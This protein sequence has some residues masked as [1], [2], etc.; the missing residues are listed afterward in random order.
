MKDGRVGYL[1]LCARMKIDVSR[2]KGVPMQFLHPGSAI[3]VFVSLLAAGVTPQKAVS[4]KSFHLQSR[5]QIQLNKSSGEIDQVIELP[6]GN[7]MVRDST[8]KPLEAQAVEI[9]GSDG[10]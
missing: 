10:K 3:L 7:I 8:F 5:R 6:D 9:Y 1:A 2:S 4:S